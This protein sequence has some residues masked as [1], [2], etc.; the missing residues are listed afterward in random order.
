MTLPSLKAGDS[1]CN[2]CCLHLQVL[3]RLPE[4]IGSGV[5]YPVIKISF[6]YIADISLTIQKFVEEQLE[7]HDCPIHILIQISSSLEEIYV[8]IAHYAYYPEVGNATIQCCIDEDSRQ[9]TI[10]LLDSG[11]PLNPLEKPDADITL[12]ADE[13]QIGELG[14]L[15]MKKAMDEVLYTYQDGYNILTLKK[16]L[17]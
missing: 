17:K 1:Q 8:N 9:I 4:R 11:K 10:R 3:H 16:V 12:S 7:S 2:D 13:R 5:S 14:I 15:M 6:R